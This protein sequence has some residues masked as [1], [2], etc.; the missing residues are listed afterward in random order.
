M[1][2]HPGAPI[3]GEIYISTDRVK[4][5]AS[6]Q[7]TSIEQELHR[8]IFHGALHLCGYKDKQK[9]QQN[10]MRAREDYYLSRYGLL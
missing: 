1:S 4:D 8:V 3:E 7:H 9:K 10:E 6:L 5:N 2:E